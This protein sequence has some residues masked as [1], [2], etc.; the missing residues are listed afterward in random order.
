MGAGLL[1]IVVVG[2]GIVAI[3]SGNSGFDWA[4]GFCIAPVMEKGSGLAIDDKGSG[5]GV[6]CAAGEFGEAIV[7]AVSYVLQKKL[8]NCKI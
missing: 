5:E 1:P 6:R 8:K 2:S 4:I 3:G 7:L